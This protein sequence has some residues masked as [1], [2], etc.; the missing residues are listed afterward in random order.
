MVDFSDLIS[1]FWSSY[2]RYRVVVW[3]FSCDFSAVF[4]VWMNVRRAML[5]HCKRRL[6][7]SFCW[8]ILLSYFSGLRDGWKL[9]YVA[10]F[11][12]VCLAQIHG[13]DHVV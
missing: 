9:K 12:G 3:W 10:F 5:E 1:G 4:R 2:W 7:Q 13:C 6:V 8:I 11:K